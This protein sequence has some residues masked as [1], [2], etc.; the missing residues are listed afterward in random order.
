MRQRL[1][2][3]CVLRFHSGVAEDSFPLG[4]GTG[5]L[6]NGSR[7]EMSNDLEVLTLEDVDIIYSRTIRIQLPNDAAPCRKRM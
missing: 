1:A 2:A 3:L 7:I 4:C 6:G 5:P